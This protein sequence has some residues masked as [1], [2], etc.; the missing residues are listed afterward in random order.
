MSP[1][2]TGAPPQTGTA[3]DDW[4][5]DQVTPLLQGQWDQLLARAGVPQR[6]LSGG[7]APQA[8]R[9]REL[10]AWTGQAPANLRAVL[11]ALERVR[12]ELAARI[13]PIP[14]RG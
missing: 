11:T 3:G 2:R 8:T 7:T 4:L 10:V 6:F 13:A 1:P 5:L 9:A 12:P 14:D